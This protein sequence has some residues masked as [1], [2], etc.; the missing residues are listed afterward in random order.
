MFPAEFMYERVPSAWNSHWVGNGL[1]FMA[2]FSHHWP[3]SCFLDGGD[4]LA[5]GCALV[6]F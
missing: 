1:S 6:V 5:E 2:F 3:S 4:T